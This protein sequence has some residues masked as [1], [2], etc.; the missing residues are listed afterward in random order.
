MFELGEIMIYANSMKHEIHGKSQVSVS[1]RRG[2]RFS[3]AQ[4]MVENRG[5]KTTLQISKVT[6]VFEGAEKPGLDP[7]HG[8][9]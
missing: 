3:L 4:K 9:T 8:N 2:A 6:R 7:K 1:S 5:R